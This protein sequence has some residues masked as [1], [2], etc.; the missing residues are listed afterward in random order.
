MTATTRW[1]ATKIRTTIRAT[2]MGGTITR[3]KMT[4]TT[5][6]STEMIATTPTTVMLA[7]TTV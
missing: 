6:V 2:L 3:P 4:A 1:E 5:E 7:E